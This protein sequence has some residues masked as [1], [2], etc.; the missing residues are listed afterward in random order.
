MT[1]QKKPQGLTWD[2][3][4][5]A[6]SRISFNEKIFLLENLRVMI[7]AG[8]SIIEAF[9]IIS[10]QTSNLKLQ[11]M[12]QGVSKEVEAG[13]SLSETLQNYPDL[14]PSIYVKMIGAGEI[15]GK[16]D[17][18]LDQIVIQMKK[19]AA[20][21]SKIRGAMIYPIVILVA[22]IG[23]AIEMM[24]LVLPKLLEIF[25][26]MNVVLP[27]PT[28]IL[29]TVSNA[30][31]KNTFGINNTFWFIG[32]GIG[33]FFLFQR[34][35]KFP[36]FKF[37]IHAVLLKTPIFG[38]M[39]KEINLARFT[40]TLSS[41]SK[42]AIPIIDALNITAEVVGNVHYHDALIET[43]QQLKTGETISSILE[44]Y[45][46]LFPPLVTQM[47]LVGE[48]S[49]SVESLLDELST[50][51]NDEV[52]QKLKNISTIIEPVII[53]FLGLIVGGLAVAVIM[54]M[55]ALTEAV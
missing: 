20:M 32:I 30:F 27:L 50:Y 49:G 24:V 10:K 47:L 38:K 21:N 40:L 54:P 4:S 1:E 26:E 18:S 22:I 45:P 29:I 9:K 51:Y 39:S 31:I 17:E 12:I 35:K 23:I 2:K 34:L 43:A 28:R 6:I 5:L 3:I 11:I 37:F 36:A 41:L 48:R 42:S 14:F 8:L 52:D 13:R 53:L 46:K 25:V 33:A 55:Y 15:S 7:K 44:K 19:T 16:L